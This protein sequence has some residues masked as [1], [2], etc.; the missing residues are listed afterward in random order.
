MGKIQKRSLEAKVAFIDLCCK[1]WHDEC[2]MTIE[3]AKLDF[4]DEPIKELLQFRVIKAE[5]EQIKID[6]LDFQIDNIQNISKINSLNGLKSAEARRKKKA[7]LERISTTVEQNPTDNSRVDE[8][9]TNLIEYFFNDFSTSSYL[10]SVAMAT[11]ADKSELIKV[12]PDFR[13]AANLSYPKGMLDFANHFKN[14]YL[15]QKK[16]DTSAPIKVSY[17]PKR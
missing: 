4:G 1:Y 2:H 17:T 8:N 9:K 3:D 5:G 7:E 6:F 14:W 16:T 15:K 12:L 13:K 10:D 11:K